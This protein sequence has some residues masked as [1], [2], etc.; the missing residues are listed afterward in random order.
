M[1]LG[2]EPTPMLLST[3]WEAEADV[4]AKGLGVFSAVVVS[5]RGL[6]FSMAAAYLQIKS[7]KMVKVTSDAQI[8][9]AEEPIGWWPPL[10]WRVC[11]VIRLLT[12]GLMLSCLLQHREDHKEPHKKGLL[13]DWG[14]GCTKC[15]LN[16]HNDQSS[17]PLPPPAEGV[18]AIILAPEVCV[19][20][21]GSLG[22][23]RQPA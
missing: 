3:D 16:K 6:V 10:S 15:F 22:L 21:G 18:G 14:E 9:R 23:V 2:T 17:E 7:T 19:C 4:T 20:V 8:K 12:T 13:W 11:W 1:C 5:P